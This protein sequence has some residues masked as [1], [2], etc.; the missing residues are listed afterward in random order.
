MHPYNFAHRANTRLT[1]RKPC[2]RVRTMKN[3]P[4]YIR[5]RRTAL[6]YS[7]KAFADALGF[8]WRSI[9]AWEAGERTPHERTRE[10]VM[11]RLSRLPTLS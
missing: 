2:Q 10:Y 5:E 4:D 9:Y 8:R 3:W 1:V 6:G 11:D 7:V